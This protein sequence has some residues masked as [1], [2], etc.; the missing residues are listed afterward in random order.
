MVY[1]DTDDLKWFPFVQT[2]ASEN[3]GKMREESKEYLLELFT[4]Y[5]DN[6]LTFVR[7]KCT[8]SMPQVRKDT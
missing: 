6:A 8:V 7:K 4:K 1:I 3:C 2:W 5:I